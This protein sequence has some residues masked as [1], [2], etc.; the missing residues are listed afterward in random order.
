MRPWQNACTRSTAQCLV[1][2]LQSVDAVLS[3]SVQ[4]MQIE[5]PSEKLVRLGHVVRAECQEQRIGALGTGGLHWTPLGSLGSGSCL[6]L[7]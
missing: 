1:L 5:V 2:G 3:L 6:C 4:Y 7:I